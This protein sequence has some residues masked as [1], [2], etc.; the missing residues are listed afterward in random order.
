[1]KNYRTHLERVIYVV[2]G[3]VIAMVLTRMM[4]PE[5]S[6]ASPQHQGLVEVAIVYCGDANSL[7]RL[8]D[9]TTCLPD[10]TPLFLLTGLGFTTF[11]E[12]VETVDGWV[13]PP[14]IEERIETN[15]LDIEALQVQVDELVA[16]PNIEALEERV[17]ANEVEIVEL[18]VRLDEWVVPTM[19]DER[20]EALETFDE[21]VA[22]T[23]SEMLGALNGFVPEPP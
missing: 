18:N 23:F 5:P 11:F 1:M 2:I 7:T 6:F 20:I 21:N 22:D 10:Q 13:A 19:L 8:A 3:I 12:T 4:P 14:D 9:G 16:P 15:A 17:E